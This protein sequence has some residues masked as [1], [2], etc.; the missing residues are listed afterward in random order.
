MPIV[1]ITGANGHGKG[2]FAIK[3]ILEIQAQN[4][5]LEKQGKPRRQIFANIHG[6]N[7]QGR[8][9]LKDVKPIPHDKI[10][11]GKQDDPE[12]PPPDG[13]YLPP[14]GSIFMYDECQEIDWVKNKSGALSNDI[15]V[16]SLEKHRHSGLDVYF[17][18]QSPNYIHSH[19][20]GLVSPHYYVE[21]P[22]GMP[23]TNVF[24]YNR[25]QKSPESPTTK[26]KADDQQ[27][28][29]LGENYGK[30]YKSSAQHNMKS[31]IPLKIKIAVLAFI[32]ALLYTF[33]KFSGTKYYNKELEPQP[34]VQTELQTQQPSNAS[35]VASTQTSE[36]QAKQL[37]AQLELVT[38][39]LELYKQRLTPTYQI[40]AKNPEIRVGG[41]IKTADKCTAYNSYGDKLNMGE[42]ECQYYID[43]NRILRTRQNNPINH[44]IHIQ[45]VEQS[46]ISPV[47]TIKNQL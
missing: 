39:E 15:R 3:K 32:L 22:L 10:F 38:L 14:I 11:F 44:D 21:R 13:Y 26:A 47:E 20:Q 33:I 27:Q 16:Q 6:I 25:Y 46:Q 35:A 40:E 2:Q 12:N 42:T 45:P 37:Q 43:D 19:I 4:D 41:V 24:M 1:L 7:E 29:K 34:Q 9:P 5:K 28:I 36:Q 30:Y 23:L 31:H 17:I 8:P 18:T